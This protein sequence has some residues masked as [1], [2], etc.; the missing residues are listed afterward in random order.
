[1]RAAA[2]RW[3]SVVCVSAIRRPAPAKH[4]SGTHRRRC[5]AG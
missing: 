4:R 2:P 3:R 1:M 5:A